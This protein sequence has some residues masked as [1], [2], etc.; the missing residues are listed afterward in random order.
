MCGPLAFAL[1]PGIKEKSSR[2]FLRTIGYNSGRVVSYTMLGLIMGLIG[3]F[4][5]ISGLQKPMAILMGVILILLFFMS[6]DIESMLFKSSRYRNVF[7]KY[8]TF[9]SATVA[10]FSANNSLLM[11]MLNGFVPCGLVYLALA[12]AMTSG[13]VLNGATFMLFF[14]LGTFP[15]MFALLSSYSFLGL[16][17]RRKMKYFF[18]YLQLFVGVFLIYRGL[19]IDI[20]ANL[21]L[22]W[23]MGKV[24]CH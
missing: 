10:K 21:E 23:S 14:G 18:S 19:A 7:S 13:G 1:L 8:R 20:P 17:Q 5:N 16:K 11:G 12:G 4:V 15:T 24:M 6:M 3:G 2:N 22:L 9:L